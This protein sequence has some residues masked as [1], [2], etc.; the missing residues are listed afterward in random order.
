MDQLQKKTHKSTRGYT[1]TYYL[2]RPSNTTKAALVLCHGWPDSAHLFADILPSLLP[3][4]H[5]ILIPD[6]LGYGG[7]SKPKNV[8]AYN[9]K[10]LTQDLYD[11]IDAEGFDKIIPVGHDW[12]SWMAQRLHLWQ[13]SRCVGLILLNVA[14]LPPFEELFDLETNLQQTEAFFG[15]P[16][17]AYWDVFASE[18]G[19]QLLAN[20]AETVF[21]CI[22]WNDP[23]AVFKF[24]CRRSKTREMLNNTSP[25]D[26]P[27]QPYAQRPGFKEA[28]LERMARDGF[29]GPQAYYKAVVQN[30]QYESEKSLP[31]EN[32]TIQEPCL[33]IWTTGDAVCRPEVM[34]PAKH[35]VQDLETVKIEGAGHWVPYEK[36]EAVSGAIVE[37]LRRKF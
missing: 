35:L 27:L 16:S 14:Y 11:V 9:S 31:K 20:K 7:S 32:L 2:H 15:Y 25:S 33:Y 19:T 12:G 3:L 22:H 36:P 6:L 1:Y 34:E 13:P 28:W 26:Y 21:H 4:G 24:F 8:Q 10:D 37:W 5:P 17:Y 18:D 23:E 30:V 29:E